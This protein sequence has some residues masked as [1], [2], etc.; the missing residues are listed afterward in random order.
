MNAS[1]PGDALQ[2]GATLEGAPPVETGAPLATASGR[3]LAHLQLRFARRQQRT[4][5]V[6]RMHSGPLVVQ[7]TLHPEGDQTCHA[8]IVHPPG[9]VA[10]GDQL[11]IQA[12]LEEGA[13][14][15]L[16]TPGAGKWYKA[17]G[18]A[19]SQELH[20]DIADGAL[21]EWLPQETILFDAAQVQMQARIALTGSA[22]YAG[23]E[24]LCLGRRAAGERFRSGHWSQQLRIFR[25]DE[26]IWGDYADVR[27]DDPLLYSP[28]GMAG[29]SVVGRLLVAAGNVPADILE[30]CRAIEPAGDAPHAIS[31]LPGVCVAT[32]IGDD[33]E[34]IRNY[35]E[36]LWAVLRPWYA[37]LDAKRP[38]IWNT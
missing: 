25:D 23:W 20:F 26:L 31:A 17:N 7:K 14:A 19:A 32:C 12:A 11:R 6:A 16:T 38:R 36:A 18:H 33:A 24:V 5:L 4:V 10:G 29:R 9:G 30:Q 21:L 28:I 15:L 22:R 35:F 13:H 27:G 34:A 1:V 2:A 37:M 3:W 8:V